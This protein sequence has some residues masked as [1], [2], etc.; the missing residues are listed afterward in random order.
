MN[1]YHYLG[2]EENKLVFFLDILGFSGLVCRN[3]NTKLSD[4]NGMI[5]NFVEAFKY[6]NEYDYNIQKKNNKK[7]K[8]M[9]VSDSLVFTTDLE[10]FDV[11]ME[12]VSKLINSFFTHGLTIRGAITVGSIYHDNNIWGPAY[13][14]AVNLEKNI[15]KY[16]RIIIKKDDLNMVNEASEFIKFFKTTEQDSFYYYDYFDQ[17]ISKSINSGVDISSPLGIYS[18]FIYDNLETQTLDKLEK[19][20]W[21]GN[22]LKR[23]L[24]ENTDYLSRNPKERVISK[25]N[26]FLTHKWMLED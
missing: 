9:W 15:S 10:N 22:E 26:N 20:I 25:I 8:F 17:F 3:K 2:L 18:S 16:P 19:Y 24:T 14:E 5:I 12:E 13:M 23:G 21:L 6:V 4:T 11:V 1:Y 7:F